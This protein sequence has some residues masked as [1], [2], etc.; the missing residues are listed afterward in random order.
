MG[1]CCYRLIGYVMGLCCYRLIGYVMGLCCYRLIGYVM[2]LEKLSTDGQQF[3]VGAQVA[4]S[5]N[6][7][8]K[9]DRFLFCFV[10]ITAHVT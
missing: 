3:F 9:L 7:Q 8:L 6:R 10:L 1:L 2:G 5:F 4:L